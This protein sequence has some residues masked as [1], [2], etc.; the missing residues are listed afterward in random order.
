MPAQDKLTED[1]PAQGELVEDKPEADKPALSMLLESMPAQGEL[2][3]DKP[4][5]DK[6]ALSILVESMPAQRELEEDKPEA[7]KPALSMLVES[8]PAQGELVVDKLGEQHKRKLHQMEADS[9]AVIDY[10]CIIKQLENGEW[11]RIE[12]DPFRGVFGA[13]IASYSFCSKLFD[14][15]YHFYSLS[16]FRY[17]VPVI[18]SQIFEKIKLFL[19]MP[20]GT[21]RSCLMTK[22]GD[23]KFRDTVP[24]SSSL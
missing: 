7:D 18:T 15:Y 17:Y 19:G 11:L 5:A 8:M 12:M 16:L 22:T 24:L 6:P 2:V 20:I 9:P 13:V 14:Q 23:E 10:V 21:R 3:E 4:E 1:M